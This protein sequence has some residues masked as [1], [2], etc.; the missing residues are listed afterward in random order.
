[1][2]INAYIRSGISAAW[3]KGVIDVNLTIVG[4]SSNSNCPSNSFSL[5]FLGAK[6]L[7]VALE[8]GHFLALAVRLLSYLSR[9]ISRFNLQMVLHPLDAVLSYFHVHILT[10][11]LPTVD[12]SVVRYLFYVCRKDPLYPKSPAE[13]RIFFVGGT[14]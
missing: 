9:K 13:H 14:K 11:T 7:G 5:E 6:A 2:S 1:M 12:Q 4:S 3:V 8:D 10:L